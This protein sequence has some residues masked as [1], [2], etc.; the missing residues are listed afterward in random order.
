MPF[1]ETSLDTKI[2]PAIAVPKDEPRFEMLRDSSETARDRAQHRADPVKHEP[3]D[4]APLATPA[5]Q[6]AALDHQDRHDHQESVIIVCTP[7]TSACGSWL[8]SLI[9]TTMFEP[10]KLQ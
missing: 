3:S 1:P 10:S 4:G 8:M 6:L 7:L 9:I 2:V 5:V